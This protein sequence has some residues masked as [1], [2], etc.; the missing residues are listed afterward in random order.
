MA[1]KLFANIPLNT[2]QC[3][4]L[5]VGVY[6]CLATENEQ[7]GSYSNEWVLLSKMEVFRGRAYS[8][9]SYQL[10]YMDCYK[11]VFYVISILKFPFHLPLVL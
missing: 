3:K 10:N 2:W 7:T 9:L 11:C 6:V 1:L 4:P 5:C 8:E